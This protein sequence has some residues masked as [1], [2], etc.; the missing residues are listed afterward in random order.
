MWACFLHQLQTQQGRVWFQL[1]RGAQWRSGCYTPL[2]SFLSPQPA[3]VCVCVCFYYFLCGRGG[4]SSAAR[5]A[6][7]VCY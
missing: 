2:S 7:D 4:A 1:T 6:R 3:V 5:E